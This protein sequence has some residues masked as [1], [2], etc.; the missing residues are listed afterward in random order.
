MGERVR[1]VDIATHCKTSLS[2]VSEI[3]ANPDHPRY[4]PETRR[5]VT[6]MARGLGY[7]AHALARALATGKSR[8]VGVSCGPTGLDFNGTKA[9]A[10]AEKIIS[11]NE[12]HLL[13]HVS[14]DPSDWHNL[15]AQNQVDFLIALADR[16]LVEREAPEQ[17][18]IEKRIAIVGSDNLARFVRNHRAYLWDDVAG[19]RM[20]VDYLLRHGH[21]RVAL[22]RGALPL[23]DPKVS[24]ALEGLV[25]AGLSPHVVSIESEEDSYRAGRRM[26]AEVIERDA[27]TSAVFCRYS[28]LAP[29][30][31]AEAR[32]RGL[33]VPDDLSVIAYYD[34]QDILGLDP[35]L[36]CVHA[37]IVEATR[38]AL[39]D[40]F[41]GKPFG[42]A[43]MRAFESRIV[44]RA[45]VASL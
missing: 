25:E 10:A 19:G 35:P 13:L 45:S 41:S 1:L 37:P 28:R 2:T 3:M 31:Y 40:Y 14:Q 11:A 32:S 27:S 21:R 18:N 33:R 16:Q 24:G 15:L 5:R 29:G 42:K 30:V 9:I 34:H 43:G 38:Q 7:R 36:T 12:H 22:L 44:E 17:A 4:S 8:V 23:T 26:M 6:A 20:A 39:Q